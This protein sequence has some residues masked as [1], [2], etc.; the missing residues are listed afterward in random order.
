MKLSIIVPVYNAQ[1][2][3]QQ[4]L[5]SILEQTW[6]DFELILINDGSK[7]NSLSICR[8]YEKKDNRV[9][10]IDKENGGAG[11][12]RNAGLDRAGG[13]YVLFIDAD[14]TVIPEMAERMLFLMEKGTDLV[15]C[16]HQEQTEGKK[17]ITLRKYSL[18]SD[19]WVTDD[20][21]ACFLEMDR[22]NHFCYL[23][24][25]LF[26][27]SI[28]FDNR[29]RFHNRFI[30]GE[31]LDFVLQ[32][33]G[34]ISCCTVTNFAPY[35]YY[36]NGTNSLCAR[37][38]KGLYEMVSELSE[39][40]MQMYRRLGQ[41]EIEAGKRTY[42]DSHI[43]YL[44]SCIPNMFRMNAD[45]SR[46]DRIKLMEQLYHDEKLR[47]YMPTFKPKNRIE[48]VYKYLFLTKTPAQ[49]VTFYSILFSVRNRSNKIYRILAG[50]KK[51][52]TS[53]A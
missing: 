52:S 41:L 45:L 38:K 37:Y 2:R 30:T 9:V 4:C 18:E 44:H 34:H 14:D 39:E 20:L 11:E 35:I 25:K 21:S 51:L 22:G 5:D 1:D 12:A 50:E 10:V 15:C 13:D 42:Q 23:W 28:I 17:E 33:Y 48:K 32:Y 19:P 7:D 53:N 29:I 40:R 8:D 24:N 36:S 6:K 16:A 27:R 43:N 26:K 47:E 31:D 46:E 49:A 3:L